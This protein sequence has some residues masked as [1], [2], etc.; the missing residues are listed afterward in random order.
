MFL[1][2]VSREDKQSLISRSSRK[3][4]HH[5]DEIN[6][7]RGNADSRM[8][9]TYSPPQDRTCCKKPTCFLGEK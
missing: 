6:Q 2:V 7:K 4:Q 1:S 8:Q 9:G 5:D 3:R